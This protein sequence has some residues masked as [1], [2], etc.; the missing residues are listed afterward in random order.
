MYRIV[1]ADGFTQVWMEPERLLD[2]ND[3]DR[4]DGCTNWERR[5]DEVLTIVMELVLRDWTNCETLEETG[6]L[7]N[8][9]CTICYADDVVLVAEIAGLC[10]VRKVL[11]YVWLRLTVE[12]RP[13][14]MNGGDWW[15]RRL[16]AV[17]WHRLVENDGDEWWLRWFAG[18][19]GHRQ[20]FQ[21]QRWSFT[22]DESPKDDGQEEDNGRLICGAVG[23]SAE[24][25]G[26]CCV[27]MGT[28]VMRLQADMLKRTSV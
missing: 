26:Q 15:L 8:V 22:L 27:L 9:L 4:A 23:R 12:Y 18:A 17:W 13:M 10:A 19:R 24:F 7:R 2:K 11:G 25:L 14:A 1:A 16:V 28:R 6:C 3:E 5:R 20:T 21:R